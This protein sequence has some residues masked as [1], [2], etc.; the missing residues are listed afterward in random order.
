MKKRLLSA[1][2]VLTMILSLTACG[3]ADEKTSTESGKYTAGTYE[4]TAKG[5]GG[6]IKATVTLTAD[7]IESITI[8]G[9]SETKGIGSVA[10]EQ[11]GQD[12][13]AKQAVEIDG[14]SGATVSSTAI[15]VALV[16]VPS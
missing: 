3:K 13:V 14:V 1:I 16:L 11:L 10:V 8:V 7:K 9:D 12:M 5:F 15:K 6:E 2:L 4:G